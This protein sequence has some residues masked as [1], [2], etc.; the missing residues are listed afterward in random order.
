[1]PVCAR[2]TRTSGMLSMA[3]QGVVVKRSA[4]KSMIIQSVV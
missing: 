3:D 1:M 4:S 2:V